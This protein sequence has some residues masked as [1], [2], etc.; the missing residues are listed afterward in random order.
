MKPRDFRGLASYPGLS[1]NPFDLILHRA[2]ALE[3]I[4]LSLFL[5]FLVL[6]AAIGGLRRWDAAL[7]YLL[8][9]L[10]DLLLLSL[11]PRLQISFG[12]AKPPALALACLRLL[13]C[14]LPFWP[15]AV[16]QGLGTLLVL[17]G[18]FV[19]PRHVRLTQQKF[20]ASSCTAHNSLRLLHLSD[21][22]I[23]RLSRRE[24]TVLRL[25]GDLQPDVIVFTGD[26]LNLSCIRDARAIEEARRFL[27]HLVAPL[28]VY[29][30]TGSPAVDLPEHFPAILEGT[31]VTWLNNRCLTLEKSG[32]P[33]TLIGVNCSHQP[34]DDEAILAEILTEKP[35][36]PRILLYHSPDLA[37]LAARYPIDLQLSG[38]THGGQVRLPLIGALFTGSLYGRAFQAGRYSL[39]NLTLYISRGMGLEGA[40]APRVRFLCPPEIIAWEIELESGDE[41]GVAKRIEAVFPADSFGIS[42]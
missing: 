18:F 6:L 4:P 23:E 27:T 9:F 3:R 30:V 33:F 19:E 39:N 26:I 17:Y 31:G 32:Q 11:L 42:R 21:L 14:W 41:H 36:G 1:G 25:V 24:E 34:D 35:P 29:F 37:P 8:A 2:L 16:L 38:H 5:G 13:V 40:A 22:H 10:L 12:P 15:L 20:P 7:L 28:G